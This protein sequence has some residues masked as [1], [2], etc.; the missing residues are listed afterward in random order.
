MS[1]GSLCGVVWCLRLRHVD[2]GAR[3]ATDH[4]YAAG[5]LALHEVLGDAD[6]E[7]VGA[8][9][10]NTPELLDAVV[11]VVDGVEVLGEASRCDE[12]V[13]LAVLADDIGNR[14]IDGVGV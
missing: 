9:H 14:S 1:D 5:A 10:V 8:V 13:D 11:G 12:V 6:R 7:Q 4:Y 3:H 2:D